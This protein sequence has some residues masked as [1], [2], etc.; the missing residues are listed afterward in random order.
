MLFS[1][2]VEHLVIRQH[3]LLA[4]F[5]TIERHVLNESNLDILIASLLDKW[6]DHVIVQT[7]HYNRIDL[8]L[9]ACAKLVHLMYAIDAFHDRIKA[10]PACK[11]LKFEW[12]KGIQADIDAG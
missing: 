8:K 6:Q 5:V 7:A 10:L 4:P 1:N 3:L 11:E 2:D 12:I 9:H